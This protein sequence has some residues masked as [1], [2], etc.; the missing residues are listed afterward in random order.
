MNFLPPPAS[1]PGTLNVRGYAG[2]LYFSI[3]YARKSPLPKRIGEILIERGKLDPRERSSARCACSRRVAREDRR[4]AGHARAC[5]AQ[6]DVAEALAR[7]ARAA[8]ASTPPAI[9][10]S[11]F[12]EERISARFLRESRALPLREDDDELALAMADPTDAYTH[13]RVRR[14]SPAR[15]VRADGRHAH[16]ARGRARAA[17]RRRQVGAGPDHRRRRDA[18][19]RAWPS[20]PTSQQLKDLAV[21]GAGH[22]P[23]EPAHHQRARDARLRHPHRA[24]REPAASCATASTACCTRSS[25]R[26]SACRPRSISRIKIMADARHRRAPPAAGRPH[27]AARAGQG[28]RPAR[29]DRA[30]HARRDRS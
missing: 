30:D 11:R 16:R 28:D 23:G 26:R 17:L 3:P 29:L 19:R 8:A 22:P 1:N 18:R 6:R 15:T 21:R 4:A 14:W 24:V 12:L 10:S 5:V 27:P 2:R 13:R 9:P 25:R 7:A 20:T